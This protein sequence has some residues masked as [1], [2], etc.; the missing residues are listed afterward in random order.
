MSD[1]KHERDGKE[2]V[3][4]QRA[5]IRR[6]PEFWLTRRLYCEHLPLTRRQSLM[7]GR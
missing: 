3:A 6:T 2:S 5:K 4:F 1:E 7:R